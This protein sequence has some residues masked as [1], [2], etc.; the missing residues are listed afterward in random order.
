MKTGI[1]SSVSESWMPQVLQSS[2]AADILRYKYDQLFFLA[3]KST[4]SARKLHDT[5]EYNFNIQ[6]VQTHRP[7]NSQY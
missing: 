7:A 1:N 4:F 6:L 5:T 2:Q 3:D